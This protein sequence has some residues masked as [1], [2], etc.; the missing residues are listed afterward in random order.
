[1]KIIVL[2]DSLTIRMLIEAYLEELGVEENYI[3]SFDNGKIALEYIKENGAD[4]IFTDIQMPEMDGYE[5]VKNV[6]ELNPSFV[7]SIFVI[8]GDND[9]KAINKMKLVGAHRFIKKPISI[10]FFNHFVAPEINKR[11][12]KN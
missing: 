3:F 11:L 2:D 4:I 9:K 5:F 12:L 10:S 1:M 6:L 8:S 7:S